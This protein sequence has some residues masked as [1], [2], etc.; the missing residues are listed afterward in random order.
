MRS[1]LTPEHKELLLN[2]RNEW[3]D[4]IMSCWPINTAELHEGVRWIYG[5][6]GLPMPKIFYATSPYEL[7]SMVH[8]DSIDEG[9]NLLMHVYKVFYPIREAVSR[10]TS[11][12]WETIWQFTWD[13]KDEITEI[14]LDELGPFVRA[15]LMDMEEGLSN[16]W[17]EAYSPKDAGYFGFLIDLCQ[18][19]GR[20]IRI[21]PPERLTKCFAWFKSNVWYIFFFERAVYVCGA[22]QYIRLDDR[23]RLHNSSGP[24]MCWSDGWS[25]YAWHGV[26]VPRQ[27]IEHP[28]EITRDTLVRETNAERRR[29]LME[30]LGSDRFAALLD[31]EEVHREA[32]GPHPE[33]Q[34]EAVLLRTRRID[35]VSGEHLQFVRV[36]C[37]STGRV[38]HL[39]VPPD[40][41][42]AREAVAWTFGKEA[43][44]YLPLVEA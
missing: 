10:S 2:L 28:E 19:I 30:I 3:I 44:D 38:Y 11:D 4:R 9:S 26:P 33:L 37:P 43:G 12:L 18:R 17:Y 40:V 16:L 35:P 31:L 13:S 36:T 8:W 6:M 25:V 1:R 22:P 34:Q 32:W 42:T 14:T 39:C 5:E 41:E 27:W 21:A 20:R 7:F 23:G 24:A 29:A 15:A